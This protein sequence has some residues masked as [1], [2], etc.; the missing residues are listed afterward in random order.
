ME[1]VKDIEDKI[2][3]NEFSKGEKLPS[4]RNLATRYK[5][6]RNVIREAISTLRARG[7]VKIKTGKGIFVIEPNEEIAARSLEN[8]FRSFKITK[9][10]VLEVRE[11]LELIIIK[12]AIHSITQSDLDELKKIYNEMEKSR[13]DI[14]EY[15]KRDEEFH[16]TLAKSTQNFAFYILVHSFFS[17]TGSEL[18]ALTE[19]WPSSISLA[20]E[21]HGLILKAIE[22]GDE[23][24]ASKTII[25]HMDTIRETMQLQNEKDD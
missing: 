15:I 24:L 6:S 2:K 5:V 14:L 9:L 17:F 7:L 8:V 13:Y 18:F 10:D 22:E 1:I 20:Q 4:E 11:E 16:L 23:Q 3:S 21:H 12:K 19:T 25:K